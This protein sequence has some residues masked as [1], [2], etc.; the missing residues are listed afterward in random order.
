M[1]KITI[2]I[3]DMLWPQCSCGRFCVRC[4]DDEQESDS[5]GAIYGGGNECSS[6]ADGEGIG[7]AWNPRRRSSGSNER[8]S[9]RGYGKQPYSQEMPCEGC[10]GGA[11]E[12]PYDPDPDRDGSFA[13][14][15]VFEEEPEDW[16]SRLC[17]LIL[18]GAEGRTAHGK[19]HV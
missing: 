15:L 19:N 5:N 6:G 14:F 17:R 8:P 3:D 10:F 1:M 11:A 9:K 2:T 7:E 4:M 12:D 13:D 16:A 18:Y